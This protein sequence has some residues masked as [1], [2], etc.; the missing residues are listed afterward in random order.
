MKTK[1]KEKAFNDLIELK[2]SHEKVKNIEYKKL[3][4]QSYLKSD[5]F[6]QEEAKLMFKLRSNMFNVKRNFSSMYKQNFNCRLCDNETEDQ[7][8]L[9]NCVW[10][11]KDNDIDESGKYSYMYSG[12]NEKMKEIMLIM[13]EKIRKWEAIL[14]TMT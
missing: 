12:R 1:S 3:E 7:K 8:H 13:K 4:M 5:R 6:Y 14:E 11:K 9:L 10:L 2:N